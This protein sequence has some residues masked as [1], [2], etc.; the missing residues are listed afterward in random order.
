MRASPTLVLV[1]LSLAFAAIR[2]I[3]TL[4]TDWLWF[5]SLG[6]ESVFLVTTG[7]RFGLGLGLG[8]LSAALVASSTAQA[9]RFTQGRSVSRDLIDNPVGQVLARTPSSRVALVLGL[10]FGVL[11]AFEGATWWDEVLLALHGE[12]F[13]HED[14]VLGFDAGFY[15]FTLPLLL[16]IRGA[17][18]WITLV[19]GGI[20][21]AIYLLR[22]GIRVQLTELDGQ[23]VARGLEIALPIRRHLATIAATLGVLT[24]LGTWL[25]RYT[26]LYE[27][28][29]RFAGPGYADVHGTLPLAILQAVATAIASFVVYVAI[30]RGRDGVAAVAVGVVGLFASIATAYPQLVQRFSV[31]PNE[32]TREAPHLRAHI[33]ATR[34]AF[35]LDAVEERS[36][37]GVADL[38]WDDIVANQATVRNVRLWD[39]EPLLE[40]FSQVQEIRTYYGFHEVDNDRYVIDGELR[41]IMLSPRELLASNLAPDAQTWVNRTMTYTHGYGLTLGPV[42][43]VTPQG[44]P[45]LFIQ[46]LPPKIRYPTDLDIRRP[47]LYF[48]EAM[49]D[50]V[51]VNTDNPEFDFPAGDQNQYATYAGTGGVPLGLAGRLLFALRLQSTELLFSGDVTPES[52]VLLYRQVS[53]RVRRIAPFL[54]LDRDPYLVIDEGRLVWIIDAYTTSDRFPYS[55]AISK[56]DRANYLRNAVKVT[57]DA[58]DGTVEVYR[59]DTDDPIAAAWDRAMPGLMRP[60]EEMPA[61]LRA[62]LRYPQDGFAIQSQLFATYHMEEPQIFYNRE[63]QWAVAT[64]GDSR[65]S[66]YYTVMKLPGE[67]REEFILMLPFTPASKDNLAAWMVARSDGDTYGMLRVYKFPKERMVY[68]PRMIVARINQDDRISEKLSLWNQQGSSVETGTLLVIPVD[69]SLL[70]VQPLYLRAE[71]G[72]IPELKRV[73]VAYENRIAMQPTLDLALRELFA[74]PTAPGPAA[75]GPAAPDPAAPD[76]EAGPEPSWQ[77]L[78]KEAAT[79]WDAAQDAARVGDWTGHGAALDQ[80]GDTLERL[81]ALPAPSPTPGDPPPPGSP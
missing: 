32:L 68:G 36:L 2:P 52:R 54:R 42:D 43:E 20:A 60:L 24:A 66:P 22:G 65:M 81:R 62:H 26:H 53:E 59:V 67:A 74:Q 21:M 30:E 79:H 5:R 48:G 47:E 45:E 44:L 50:V 58:Y 73:I 10:L 1:V 25:G 37:P 61:G 31:L 35:G 78:A 11:V 15:V 8:A 70:Y 72:S 75:P 28:A 23:L 57:V 33:D 27:Q 51:V 9:L 7:A 49:R 38:D 46:D 39:H 40:T 41:Q 13:G 29:G 16:H 19:A 34:V 6:L 77:Q 18:T 69:T 14:P 55:R 76:A 17:L 56:A 4:A 12:A 3:A 63:D 80:L 64:V 71:S